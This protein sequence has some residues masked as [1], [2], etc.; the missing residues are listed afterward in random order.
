MIWNII[1]R[2]ERHYRWKRVNAITEAVEQDNTCF[3]ADQANPSDPL[4]TIDYEQLEAVSVAEAIAWASRAQ[5]P[6]T[7]YIYDDGK[8]TTNEGHFHALADRF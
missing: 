8:G 2:R 3:D 6:V 1:D 7:L 4:T 5:C